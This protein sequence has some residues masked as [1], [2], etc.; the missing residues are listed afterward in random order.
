MAQTVT[1]LA[2]LQQQVDAVTLLAVGL[3]HKTASEGLRVGLA[4]SQHQLE[5]ALMAL[6][7][8]LSNGVILSTGNR[9][10]LYFQSS[11]VEEGVNGAVAF[12]SYYNCMEPGEVFPNLYIY[13]AKDAYQHLIDVAGGRNLSAPEEVKILSQMRDALHETNRLG[14]CFG[15]LDR[16]FHT[17][18]KAG[19]RAGILT[20]IS[21]NARLVSGTAVELAKTVFSDLHGLR[22]MVIGIGSTGRMGGSGVEGRRAA[23]VLDCQPHLR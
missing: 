17:A 7:G 12:L 23:R 3:N 20:S 15:P 11:S 4:V 16:V 18:M 2:S 22:A 21:R 8:P 13:E 5:E 10:E 14:L 9:T 6:E 19:E 1:E